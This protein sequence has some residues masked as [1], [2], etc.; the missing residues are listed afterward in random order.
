M[1]GAVC[2]QHPDRSA[3]LQTRLP[4]W[5]GALQFRSA[6]RLED[7]RGVRAHRDRGAQHRRLG[8]SGAICTFGDP[9]GLAMSAS[10]GGG[11]AMKVE[12]MWPQGQSEFGKAYGITVPA[13][14]VSARLH[15]E[16]QAGG[17]LSGGLPVLSGVAIFEFGLKAGVNVGYDRVCEYRRDDDVAGAAAGSRLRPRAAATDRHARVAAESGR[18]VRVFVRRLPRSH[19]RA[20]RR[21]RALRPSGTHAARPVDRHR[22]RPAPQGV[23][24]RRIQARGQLRDRVASRR[25]SQQRA[26]DA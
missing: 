16:G 26:V 5:P 21:L 13:G 7:R 19:G 17:S 3:V 15:L 12:L 10:V 23:G 14:R 22:V 25:R 18:A 1:T 4:E 20:H 6:G 11:G 2:D 8:S 9:N 24:Q